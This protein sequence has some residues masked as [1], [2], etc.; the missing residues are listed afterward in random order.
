MTQLPAWAVKI[1]SAWVAIGVLL[2]VLATQ[3][4]IPIP[5]FLPKIF[6]QGFVDATVTVIGAVLTFV[7]FVRAIFLV[8]PDAEVR[9]ASEAQKNAYAFNPFKLKVV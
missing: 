4:G 1:Q 7:Q 6:S 3:S 9:V 2:I 5:E 8:K